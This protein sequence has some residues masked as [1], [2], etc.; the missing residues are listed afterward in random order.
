MR[1]RTPYPSIASEHLWDEDD[2]VQRL[3]QTLELAEHQLRKLP[4]DGDADLQTAPRSQALLADVSLL[5]LAASNVDSYAAISPRVLRVSSLL[6][7][8]AHSRHVL[9]S[10]C[11]EPSLAFEHAI[12]HICLKR[13]GYYDPDFDAMLDL[14]AAAQASE[15]RERAPHRMLEQEWLRQSW[16]YPEGLPRLRASAILASSSLVRTIDL[17]YGTREDISGFTHALMYL[18]DFN[19]F[20]RS[21]P[22]QRECLLA[23]AEG[24]L[25]R[26]LDAGDDELVAEVLLTWPLTGES[27]SPAATFAFRVL[28]GR[29]DAH[30]ATASNFRAVCAMGVLVAAML[31]PGKRPPREIPSA[32][33]RDG[34]FESVLDC[35]CS[36]EQASHW[37]QEL[38]PLIPSEREAI[39]EFL[40]VIA[41]HREVARR[42]F[43]EL[44]RVLAVGAAVGL[45]HNPVFAQAAEMMSR[46]RQ[47]ADTLEYTALPSP[48][49]VVAVCA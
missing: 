32:T 23:E 31:A 27:W 1:T 10:I 40:L 25:A 24:M 26:A 7:P 49:S 30:A 12:P 4:S 6:A 45:T 28:A 46:I 41:I 42:D 9:R 8:H 17:L 22:R 33:V 15:G 5:L 48:G 16:L 36:R 14:A 13:L 34:A 11:L 38:A 39:S 21:L 29:M 35:I 44:E 20:P 43:A 2:L 3:G 47:F 18:R 19:L 37:Q